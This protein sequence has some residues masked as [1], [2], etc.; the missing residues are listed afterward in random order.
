MLTDEGEKDMAW[1]IGDSGFEM[2]LSAEV[3][4][5]IGR[6]I[7]GAV[8]SF[9]G[10]EGVDT[11][12]VHPGGRSVLDRVE[13]GLDLPADALTVSRDILRDYGNMSSA[14]ILF[15]LGALLAGDLDDGE[16]VATSRSDRGSRSRRRG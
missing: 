10:D 9:L 14:T 13:T 15:I 5:I 1:T 11:W 12:A 4:R 2:I 8:D 3:P 16:R 6:E 7:R